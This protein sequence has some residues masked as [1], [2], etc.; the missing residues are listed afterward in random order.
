MGLNLKNIYER[1]KELYRISMVLIKSIFS[2]AYYYILKKAMGLSKPDQ[3][4]NYN[5][6]R[7]LLVCKGLTQK[8]KSYK[9]E[10]GRKSSNKMS[11]AKCLEQL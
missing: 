4:L 1:A 2:L 3:W 7:G 10:T 11:Y 9:N 5:F 8:I 6:K